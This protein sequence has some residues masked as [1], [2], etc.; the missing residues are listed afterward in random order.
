[1]KLHR[2]LLVLPFAA[3]KHLPPTLLTTVRLIA[4]TIITCADAVL[5]QVYIY[6]DACWLTVN[7]FNAKYRG[8][9]Q[10]ESSQKRS[11]IY[12]LNNPDK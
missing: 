7:E 12:K 1:M 3:I 5:R 8:M 4:D 9:K 11:D 6:C 10:D 2:R